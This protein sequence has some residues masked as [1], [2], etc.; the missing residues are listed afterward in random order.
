M[1]LSAEFKNKQT[2]LSSQPKVSCSVPI[3][4][5]CVSRALALMRHFVLPSGNTERILL[6]SVP[7]ALWKLSK[8]VPYIRKILLLEPCLHHV[9]HLIESACTMPAHGTLYGQRGVCTNRSA[10]ERKTRVAPRVRCR[11][12]SCKSRRSWRFFALQG[13]S[14]ISA[15]VPPQLA[16]TRLKKR[17]LLRM[18]PI[19]DARVRV[20]L[21]LNRTCPQICEYRG[22]P[23]L[24]ESCSKAEKGRHTERREVA[25]ALLSSSNGKW[26]QSCQS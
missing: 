16:R 10:T 11:A 6:M 25:S 8:I 21:R 9:R 13:A 7:T 15:P 1:A 12:D 17:V 18:K 23:S 19:I 20:A 26:G 24:T 14:H 22:T 4:G 3:L 2:F 5:R